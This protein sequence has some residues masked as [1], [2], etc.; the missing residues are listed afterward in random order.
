MTERKQNPPGDDRVRQLMMAEVDREISGDGRVELAS[1]LENNPD[2]R[3]E[4]RTYQRLKEVTDTMS[5][6][7]PPEETWDSYWEHVY[8]RLERGIG[9]VLVSLGAITVGTWVLWMAVSELIRDTTMPVYV[10]WGMLVLIAGLVVL[11][12]SV[13]RERLFMQKKDPY[14]DVVR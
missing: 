12:V 2:L 9:W 7:K 8:R 13:V 10:R 1:A 4:L 5:P 3:D 11:F 14:K 6:L